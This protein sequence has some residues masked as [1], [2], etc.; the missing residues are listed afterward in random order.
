MDEMP[1][2]VVVKY[3]ND[4]FCGIY[5]HSEYDYK[6]LPIKQVLEDYIHATREITRR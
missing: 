1:I 3:L 5:L 6:L 2:V 4:N